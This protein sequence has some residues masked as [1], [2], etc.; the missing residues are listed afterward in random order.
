MQEAFTK[1]NHTPII[2]ATK[3]LSTHT[4]AADNCLVFFLK[5]LILIGLAPSQH[6][7]ITLKTQVCQTQAYEIIRKSFQTPYCISIDREREEILMWSAIRAFLVP[8]KLP[9]NKKRSHMI[10]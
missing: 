7:T 2:I 5:V 4:S 10:F 6:K 1:D 3:I 8:S 9:S